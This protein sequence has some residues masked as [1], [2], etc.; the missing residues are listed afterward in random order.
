MLK[1][2]KQE[3]NHKSNP[4]N[5][6]SSEIVESKSGSK[7]QFPEEEEKEAETKNSQG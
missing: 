3:E 4:R 6:C 5:R 7:K 1:M 2:T